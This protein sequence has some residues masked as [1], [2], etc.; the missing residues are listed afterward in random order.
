MGRDA[1]AGVGP[2]IHP[3]TGVLNCSGVVALC[4]MGFQG[5]LPKILEWFIGIKTVTVQ[6]VIKGLR[7]ACTFIN[8]NNFFN[9]LHGD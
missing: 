5:R 1:S 8:M 7:I 2:R 4:S 6:R 3:A 9:W